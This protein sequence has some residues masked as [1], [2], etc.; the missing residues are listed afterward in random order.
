M[1]GF[2]SKDLRNSDIMLTALVL[3]M[4]LS[5]VRPSAFDESCPAAANVH[6]FKRWQGIVRFGVAESFRVKGCHHSVQG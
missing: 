6:V 5:G 2:L 1:F 3:P 4:V